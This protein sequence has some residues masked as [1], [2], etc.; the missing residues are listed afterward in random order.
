MPSVENPLKRICVIAVVAALLG[1]CS[2]LNPTRHVNLEYVS[3]SPAT[4]VAEADS[5]HVAV[6]VADK[7]PTQVVGQMFNGVLMPSS[8]IVSDTDVPG[9]LKSAFETEL[10]DRGFALGPGGNLVSVT[11]KTLHHQFTYASISKPESIAD[12]GMDVAVKHPDGAISYD[13]S[14]TGGNRELLLDAPCPEANY[15][16]HKAQLDARLL[17]NARDTLNAAIRDAVSN[18]F[19]NTFIEV[20]RRP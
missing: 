20:L 19:S 3:P 1:T 17:C 11:L 5:P 16:K 15:E 18:T 6:E 12:M 14:I 13:K 9:I 2:C 10:T 7:R 8:D 4:K